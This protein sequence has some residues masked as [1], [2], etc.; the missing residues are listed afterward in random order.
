MTTVKNYMLI[1]HEYKGATLVELCIV[2][3]LLAIV[4]T[5]IVS[6]SAIV[7]KYVSSEQNQYAFIEETSRIK[8]EMQQWLSALDTRGTKIL[9]TEDR[10]Q[11]ENTDA[12]IQFNKTMRV[13]IFTYEDGSEREITTQTV[14]D[15]Q[16]GLHVLHDSSAIAKC[17]VSGSDEY[18]EEF[19]QRFLLALRC[20]SFT[21]GA[22]E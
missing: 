20:A 11:A 8:Q 18:L 10:I 17:T 12:T 9:V 1:R 2:M 19:S 5:M 15:I 21:G 4:S 7:H 6:F 14:K 13:L 3:A 22:N 16:F